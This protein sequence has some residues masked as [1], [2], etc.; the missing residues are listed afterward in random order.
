MNNLAKHWR[1][2]VCFIKG[3]SCNQYKVGVYVNLRNSITLKWVCKGMISVPAQLKQNFKQNVVSAICFSSSG[4]NECDWFFFLL[5]SV[6]FNI[7]CSSWILQKLCYFT[8]ELLTFG[9][10]FNNSFDTEDFVTQVP[11]EKN[12]S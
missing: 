7:N 5:Y 3:R 9:W 1:R 2:Q 10:S 8:S 12:L 6:A 11:T 4:I